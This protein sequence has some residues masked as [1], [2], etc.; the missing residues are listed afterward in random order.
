MKKQKSNK[1][2]NLAK[3]YLNWNKT[4]AKRNNVNSFNDNNFILL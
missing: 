4:E 2:D 1:K 3:I